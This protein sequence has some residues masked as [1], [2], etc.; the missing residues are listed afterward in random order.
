[1]KILTAYTDYGAHWHMKDKPRLILVGDEWCQGSYTDAITSS[2]LSVENSFRKLFSVTNLSMPYQTP[3]QSITIL[4]N[5]LNNI[6][7]RGRYPRNNITIVYVLGNMFRDMDIPQSGVLDAHRTSVLNVLSRLAKLSNQSL[8]VCSKSKINGNAG[9]WIVGGSTDLGHSI[10]N[11]LEENHDDSFVPNVIKS[12][13]QFVDPDYVPIPFSH[14]PDRLFVG[15]RID[16][17][18]QTTIWQMLE[19]RR[20]YNSLKDNGWLSS[21][22]IPT[23]MMTDVLAEHIH[24]ISMSRFNDKFSYIDVNGLHDEESKQHYIN[25]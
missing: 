22:Y 6:D 10:V 5:Y 14:D 7:L 4:E 16:P 12:W 23:E 18:E 1:M 21:D 3:Q 17:S 15:S 11:E 19:K 9:W 20:Q 2:D 25:R 24:N 13:C 8:P